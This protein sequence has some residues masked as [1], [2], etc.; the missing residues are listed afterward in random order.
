MSI[1]I[2]D[3]GEFYIYGD[4]IETSL[5][6]C[7]QDLDSLWIDFKSHRHNYITNI[8]PKCMKGVYGLMWY[9]H[10]HRYSYLLG[11]G[12]E[13]DNNQFEAV[14]KKRVPA[15]HYAVYSVPNGIPAINAWTLF[16]EKLL[17]EERL[18]PDTEHGLY[19]EYYKG[20]S[21]NVCELWTPVKDIE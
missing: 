12:T 7:N 3:R 15:A 16:F 10:N 2:I 8:V 18:M 6:T 14:Y 17:P 4:V 13:N 11:L 20:I 1:R 21:E 9:T 19:F 5:Q